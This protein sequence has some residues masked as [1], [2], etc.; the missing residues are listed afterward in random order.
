MT[1]ISRTSARR[2]L[3]LACGFLLMAFLL[4]FLRPGS[5][6]TE[7]LIL[8]LLIAL[9][10]LC[11]GQIA[12]L[13]SRKVLRALR[14]A[15]RERSLFK[16]VAENSQGAFYICKPMCDSSGRVVDF[17]I[18]YAN[19]KAEELF[20]RSRLDLVGESTSAIIPDSARSEVVGAWSRVA[21]T[22][23]AEDLDMAFTPRNSTPATCATRISPLGGSVAV[24]TLQSNEEAVAAS[25]LQEL[26]AFSQSIIESAPISMIAT[27]V[28]GTIMAMNSAA[29]RLTYFRKHDLVGQHSLLLLH[30]PAEISART[31]QLSRDLEEPIAAGFQSLIARASYGQQDTREWTYVRRDGS[32]ASVS[33]TM[34]ALQTPDKQITGYLAIAYDI[35]ERKK[36]TDSITHMAHY[37]QLTGLPNRI[38]L[39]DRI[40]QGIERARRFNQRMAVYMVGIDHFKRINESLGHSGGDTVLSFFSRQLLSAVR[41]TDTVA[42]VGGDEFVVLMPDF[43]D[44]TDAERC[45]HLMLQK[46]STPVNVGGSEIR[47]NASI[48]YCLFPEDGDNSETLLRNADV[49]MHEAKSG[50]RGLAMAYTGN[51]QREAADR[52]K[53]EEELRHAVQN[54]ELELH[55]QPQ[56]RCSTGEVTGMEMLLRWN[57]PRRGF[58]PPTTFIPIAEKAGLLVRIGE[59]SMR[60]ACK[61]VVKLQRQMGREL[62]VAVNL[63][64]WQFSQ[65][66]LIDVVTESLNESGLPAKSLEI[67]ITEQMLM[68]NSTTV[69]ETMRKIREL[70]VSIA[71]DD[72]GTGFSSF[73]YILQYEVDRLKIDRCFIDRSTQDAGAA[74]VVRTI[75]AMAHGLNI[76]VV[77][78]GVETTAQMNFLLRRKCDQVQGYLFSRAVPITAFAAVVERIDSFVADQQRLAAEDKKDAVS[79]L[80][81]ANEGVQSMFTNV[82]DDSTLD[83]ETRPHRRSSDNMRVQ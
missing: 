73:S 31:I 66:N 40:E 4:L 20:G 83:E 33:L 56:V 18:T 74:A 9:A 80:P 39:N 54:G 69:M 2:K 13:H 21:V 51:L 7:F 22:G 59:W 1:A 61:D 82:E 37:D 38:L 81:T 19:R 48:G 12:Y 64:A 49:A 14:L 78:E 57:N 32:R 17:R 24:S 29:E 75:I 25:R 67:E 5:G 45:A 23:V 77:A 36:L 27:D 60:Q 11:A 70:G 53:M 28:S 50:G 41:R 71:I 68:T 34:M 52:L 79:G 46:I 43:R 26:S 3:F 76:E 62:T 35:T 8:S 63:S 42:R 10:M 6:W 15:K 55:Y 16:A 65:R 47:V 44:N 30:D 72:F 58:V